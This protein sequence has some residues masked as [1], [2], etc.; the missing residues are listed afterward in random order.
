MVNKSSVSLPT[1]TFTCYSNSNFK[2]LKLKILFLSLTNTYQS[3]SC[4]MWLGVEQHS[5]K[6]SSSLQK[7]L[8]HSIDTGN[9]V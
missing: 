9:Q 1:L 3:V 2:Q 6:T 5:Y 4:H 8:L 7:V